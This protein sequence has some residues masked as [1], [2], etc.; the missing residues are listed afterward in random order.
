MQGRGTAWLDWAP[1]LVAAA[2][3]ALLAAPPSRGF[4]HRIQLENGPIEW[5]TVV[6]LLTGAVALGAAFLQA[7]PGRERAAFGAGALVIAFVAGEELAWG[8]YLLGGPIS[9]TWA[10]VNAQ[11]ETTLHNLAPLQGKAELWYFFPALAGMLAMRGAVA[12]WL[13][14]AAPSPRLLPALWLVMLQAVAE[15]LSTWF[16]QG[17]AWRL[18]YDGLRPMGEVIEMVIG[19][20]CCRYGVEAARSGVRGAPA[21]NAAA[22]RRE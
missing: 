5:A 9:E 7:R 2:Y 13:G 15:F 21:L 19:W 20:I 4:A 1:W 6:L 3:G 11:N 17:P 8:Q 22:A 14:G 12:R 10:A 16:P 18:L